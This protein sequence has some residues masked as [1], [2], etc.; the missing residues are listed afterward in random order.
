MIIGEVKKLIGVGKVIAN[1]SRGIVFINQPGFER[2]KN[3]KIIDRGSLTGGGYRGGHEKFI[4]S[5]ARRKWRQQ[6]KMGLI[7]RPCQKN[8]VVW[9]LIKNQV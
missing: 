9:V 4:I 8:L 2:L 7:F 6:L 5:R 3:D 1:S